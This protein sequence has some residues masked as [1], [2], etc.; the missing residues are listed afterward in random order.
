MKKAINRLRGLVNDAPAEAPP[1]NLGKHCLTC[2]FRDHCVA[3]AERTDSLF[4]LDKMTPKLAAKYQK[5]GIFTLTQLSY[6]Y[7]PRRRRK[8]AGK[9][10]YA[11]Q[12]RTS[13][14]GHPREEDLPPRTPVPA[15]AS[16]GTFPR[17]RRHP[18]PGLQLPC[19]GDG[20]AGRQDEDALVLGGRSRRR[21]THLRAGLA[22]AAKYPDAP[23][24]HYGAYERRAFERAAAQHGLDCDGILGRLVNVNGIVY[25]KVYFPT[26]SNRLKDLGAAVG[27]SWPT[28]DPSGIQSV[29]WRYR[30]ED[31]GTTTSRPSCSPT[32]RPTAMPFVC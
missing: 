9:V 7:R 23:I 6:V 2:E 26:R 24:Y 27:A 32:I 29:A 30:W 31:I 15:P 16:R 11:V 4:L 21:T 10:P 5:K 12:C 28:P 1:L 18:R 20:Q 25:G 17:H 19:W 3:E 22:L 14:P 13:S 8:K